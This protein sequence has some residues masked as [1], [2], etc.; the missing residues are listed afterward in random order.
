MIADETLDFVVAQLG[1]RMIAQRIMSL[2]N[3]FCSNTIHCVFLSTCSLH[4]KAAYSKTYN[5]LGP[6]V[7]QTFSLRRFMH[8]LKV[9]AT[10]EKH[11]ISKMV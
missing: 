2:L 11:N 10:K 7:A 8:K 9:C 5:Y 4:K 1:L 3:M 6:T